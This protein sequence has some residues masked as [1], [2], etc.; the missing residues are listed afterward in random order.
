MVILEPFGDD[1]AGAVLLG[2]ASGGASLRWKAASGVGRRAGRLG[3]SP[4][5]ALR[6]TGARAGGE[7]EGRR[8]VAVHL[9]DL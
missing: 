9:D 4:I 5:P 7:L 2:S 8:G 6:P 1:L 3:K